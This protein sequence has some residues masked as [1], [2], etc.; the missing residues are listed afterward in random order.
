MIQAGEH[1]RQVF[2]GVSY[3]PDDAVFIGNDKGAV[4]I[5]NYTG[6]DCELAMAGKRGWLN[7]TLIRAVFLQIFVVMG[8]ARATA[9]VAADNDLAL[10]IDKRLGFVV[11]GRLRNAVDGRDVFVLGILK[12]E[13]RWI[14]E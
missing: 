10:D 3:I 12:D 7:R 13:C 2:E 8:C 4:A 6:D 1:L 5:F 14:N 11:E 9:R